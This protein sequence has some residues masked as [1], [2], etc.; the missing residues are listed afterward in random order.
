MI[1]MLE[2]EYVIVPKGT[3][4]TGSGKLGLIHVLSAL[5]LSPIFKWDFKILQFRRP[6]VYLHA[7]FSLPTS[8]L[9]LEKKKSQ[10]YF[11]ILN[12]S[13]SVSNEDPLEIM[14]FSL[15]SAS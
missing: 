5:P 9:N 2:G 6:I 13:L 14:F 12:N 7:T 10:V 4:F 8:Y 11:K 15:K 1:L 3:K